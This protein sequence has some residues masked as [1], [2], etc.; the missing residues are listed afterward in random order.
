MCFKVAS[1]DN[2]KLNAVWPL[3]TLTMATTLLHNTIWKYMERGKNDAIIK[4]DA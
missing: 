1:N 3:D 4:A 2:R